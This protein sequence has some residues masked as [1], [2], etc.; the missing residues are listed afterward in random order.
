MRRQLESAR[1]IAHELQICLG[2]GMMRIEGKSPFV[3]ENGARTIAAAIPGVAEIVEERWVRFSSADESFV[4]FRRS[5][6][7]LGRILAI[8]FCKIRGAIGEHCLRAENQCC[9]Y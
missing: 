5:L 9:R 8:C 1:L 6:I 7:M 3:I 2:L 4:T